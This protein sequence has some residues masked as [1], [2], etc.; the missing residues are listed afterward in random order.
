MILCEHFSRLKVPEIVPTIIWLFLHLFG[1]FINLYAFRALKKRWTSLGNFSIILSTSVIA[2]AFALFVHLYLPINFLLKDVTDKEWSLGTLSCSL[3]PLITNLTQAIAMMTLMAV[4]LQN[5][6][7][8]SGRSDVGFV[9]AENAMVIMLVTSALI[10]APEFCQ[11]GVVTEPLSINGS[12]IPTWQVL[13]SG[14][15]YQSFRVLLQY[16]IPL[17][18]ILN[19][20]LKAQLLSRNGKTTCISRAVFLLIDLLSV[21]SVGCFVYFFPL[22]T[23][24]LGKEKFISQS[25]SFPAIG[26][27]IRAMDFVAIFF[28]IAAP[29]A[30]IEIANHAEEEFVYQGTYVELPTEE[31]LVEKVPEHDEEESKLVEKLKNFKMDKKTKDELIASLMNDEPMRLKNE[32][33]V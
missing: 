12:C 20:L 30:I 14:R 29:M 16:I 21:A 26:A 17:V 23:M 4:S 11:C 3:L 31:R 22:K 6:L 5:Y 32:I 13:Y 33:I 9:E 18:V 28:C 27:V 2:N 24:I 19:A 25:F 15:V 10:V 8:T 1:I 7:K